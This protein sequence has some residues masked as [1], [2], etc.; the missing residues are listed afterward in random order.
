MGVNQEEVMSLRWIRKYF[1]AG[2]VTLCAG[3]SKICLRIIFKLQI[4]LDEDIMTLKQVF[5]FSPQFW[6]AQEFCP[7]LRKIVQ[8]SSLESLLHAT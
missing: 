7:Y 3:F 5:C 2:Y 4:N 6:V 8:E 1:S